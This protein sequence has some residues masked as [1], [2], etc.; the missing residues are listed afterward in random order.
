MPESAEQK[1]IRR[2]LAPDEQLIFIRGGY[3]RYYDA[4]YDTEPPQGGGAHN[5]SGIGWERNNF[6]PWRGHCYVYTRARFDQP[7]TLQRLGAGPEDEEVGGV[8]VIQVATRPGGGQVVCG[9]FRGA[10]A[11]AGWQERPYA[12]EELCCF[13]APAARATLLADEE[14]TIPVPKGVPGAMGQS[15]VR[16]A[17]DTSGRFLLHD[18]MIDILEQMRQR[19]TGAPAG[20]ADDAA[21]GPRTLVGQGLCRVALSP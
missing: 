19:E 4:R 16:Y 17:S 3:S 18:W 13:I 21:A 14:R 11:Y 10:T 6:R 9:W 2:I 1:R 7:L 20:E 5:E 8:T 15:Q 12:R